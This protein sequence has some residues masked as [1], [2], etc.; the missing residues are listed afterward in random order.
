VILVG[1]WLSVIWGY[2]IRG[3]DRPVWVWPGVVAVLLYIALT[4]FEM[5]MATDITYGFHAFRNVAW[6][7]LAFLLVG[8]GLWQPGTRR[9]IFKGVILVALLVGAYA[10]FR[11]AVGPAAQE[12]TLASA[13][14]ITNFL[15]GELRLVGSFPSGKALACWSAIML[16]FCLAA[17]LGTEGRWRLLSAVACAGCAV[18]LLG[19]QVRSAFVGVVVGVALVFLLFQFARGIQGLHLGVTTAALLAVALVGIGVFSFT[20]G[21][22]EGSTQRY[23]LI[24]TP[25]RDPAF[26]SRLVRWRTVLADID[27]HPFGQGLGTA[28]RIQRERGRFTNISAI[29]IDNSYLG[30]AFEQGLGVLVLFLAATLM[31]LFGLARR[32][33]ATPVRER[34][35][36]AIGACGALATYLAILPTGSY[37]EGFNTLAVWMIVGLGVSQF[38]FPEPP[39]ASVTTTA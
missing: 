39:G 37:I 19:S 31:L 29:D 33:L 30:I 4:A 23:T 27:R 9:L 6:Y 38:A 12:Y 22:S 11:L 21:Q 28:G 1:L 20:G 17:A 13:A 36:V 2:L 7:M 26:Q 10:S 34:A 25:T 16:S 15:N 35:V 3:R 14:D 18:G 8:Y 32:A 24:L 5:L